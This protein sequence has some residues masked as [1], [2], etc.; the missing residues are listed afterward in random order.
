MLSAF[1]HPGTDINVTPESEAPIIPNA[2]KYHG[3]ELFALKK[4]LLLA[5]LL[6]KKDIV[7][8]SEKYPTIKSIIY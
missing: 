5:D 8:K 4:V 1:T 2:T 3:D 6:V 7:I